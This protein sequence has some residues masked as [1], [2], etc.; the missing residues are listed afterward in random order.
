[1]S[2]SK[3]VILPFDIDSSKLTFRLQPDT[4]DKKQG[5]KVGIKYGYAS[6]GGSQQCM[7]Q[8][9]QMQLPFGLSYNKDEV[10]DQ[11]TNIKINFSFGG[12]PNK[13][14]L[15]LLEKMKEFEARV[16]EFAQEN[17]KEMFG[18]KLNEADLRGKFKTNIKYS[19]DKDTGEISDKYDPTLR[20]K[21]TYLKDKN[22]VDADIKQ[23]NDNGEIENFNVLDEDLGKTTVGAS[24]M[25]VIHFVGFWYST[26]TGFGTSLKVKMLQLKPRQQSLAGY[27]MTQLEDLNN[28]VDDDMTVNRQKS[29]IAPDSD[30]DD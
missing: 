3:K 23:I 4:K 18:R 16:F 27:K 13:H 1:M 9:P 15:I 22:I 30:E 24:G 21:I 5:G 26:G 6:Y 28:D 29:L 8:T 12:K 25:A 7:F 20:C 19:V 2:D 11:L 10:T 17:S 14:K